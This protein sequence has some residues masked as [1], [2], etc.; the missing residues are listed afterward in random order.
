VLS[1]RWL[2][3]YLRGRHI[4]ERIR[5]FRKRW[6]KA[7]RIAGCPGM[8]RHDLRRTACQN[9]IN[10]GVLERVVMQVMGHK[11][12]SMLDRYAIVSP[13]DLQDAA[14]RLLDKSSDNLRATGDLVAI[15]SHG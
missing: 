4:G 6:E 8:I 13:E 10:R 3:P 7:C 2:F 14:R 15:T 5:S 9:M 11:T 12:R 1:C